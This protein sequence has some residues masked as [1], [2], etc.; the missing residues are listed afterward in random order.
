MQLE[1]KEFLTTHFN[2]RASFIASFLFF[3]S[4]AHIIYAQN[5]INC[6][7]LNC[8]VNAMQNAQ[9]GDE[10]IIASGTYI[11]NN[12]FNPDIFSHLTIATRFYAQANG[13][14]NQPITLRGEDAQNPPILQGPEGVYDGY[15]MEVTGDYWIIKDLKLK[16]GSKGL[17][18]DNANHTQIVNVEVYDI[19]QEGIHV[20]DGSSETI[21][22]N[23]YLHDLGIEQPENGEGLY[24]GSDRKEHNGNF[25]PYC[26]NTKV[27]NCTFGPNVS[28]E[29]IDVKEEVDGVIIK[30]CDFFSAGIVGDDRNDAFIDLKG[31]NSF[32]YDN[33]FNVDGPGINAGIDVIEREA[34]S[35]NPALVKTG[36]R[37]AIFDNIFNLGSSGASIPIVRFKGGDPYDIHMWDN[38]RVPNTPEPEFYF[39]DEITTSCPSW[40]ILACNTLSSTT[41]EAA[42]IAIYP[43]PVSETLY[44][45]G[46]TEHIDKLMVGNLK[47]QLF[48]IKKGATI[49]V[50]TLPNG[51]YFLM[52]STKGKSLI[53]QF[54]KK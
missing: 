42:G 16:S 44:I 52:A 9:A 50:S 38:R 1:K 26:N 34:K 37:N 29:G 10:I 17:M 36:Y 20:R 14:S 54:I 7:T 31:I 4:C 22:E 18:L 8:I 15:V 21:I 23:C 49:D 41:F 48:Y 25:N 13:Q 2:A 40:N 30:E 33:T 11:K 6:N 47:G 19:A 51:I 53:N 5:K 27:I 3:F 45:K 46:T 39:S 32:V 12:K 24:I 35:G 28:A 43:N